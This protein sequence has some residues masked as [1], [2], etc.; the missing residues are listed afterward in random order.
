[1]PKA[2]SCGRM[3][4]LSAERMADAGTDRILAQR[5]I[6]QVGLDGAQPR[7]FL[8]GVGKQRAGVVKEVRE[9]VHADECWLKPSM[10][11]HVHDI[12]LR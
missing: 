4:S 5:D 3:R 2:R 9:G 11:Q 8:V 6:D 7:Q 10:L 12:L 1:M